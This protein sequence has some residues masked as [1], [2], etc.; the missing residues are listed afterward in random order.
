MKPDGTWRATVVGKFILVEQHADAG[1]QEHPSEPRLQHD[2]EPCETRVLG[3]LRAATSAPSV[4]QLPFPRYQ[5][6]K[7]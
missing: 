6:E 5:H 4:S 1:F 2:E 3:K 7:A